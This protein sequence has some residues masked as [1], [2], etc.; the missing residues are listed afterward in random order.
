MSIKSQNQG[1]GCKRFGEAEK[2]EKLHDGP[3]L[4]EVKQRLKQ[5]KKKQRIR[6]QIGG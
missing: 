4:K 6:R 1:K 5:I 3:K 2:P